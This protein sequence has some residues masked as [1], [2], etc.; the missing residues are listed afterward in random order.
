MNGATGI[1]V[2]M[3]TNIPTHNLGEVIDGCVAMIDNPEITTEG[4][5]KYIKAP[6]FPTGG[7]I[8]GL[9][10]VKEAYETGRGRIII[11]SKTDIET[12]ATHDNCSRDSLQCE[13]VG[14]HQEDC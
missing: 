8:C 9:D 13:Q 5:M 7:I 3:A 11:R 1:A 2:G 14:A 6:D 10:G 4:L 12:E